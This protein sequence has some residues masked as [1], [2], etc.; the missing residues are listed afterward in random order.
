M[1]VDRKEIDHLHEHITLHIENKD[2]QSEFAKELRTFAQKSNLKG[3]RKGKTPLG[4]IRKM[5]GKSILVDIIQKKIDQGINDFIKENELSILGQPLPIEDQEAISFDPK[6]LKDFK[7]SFEIGISP[8]VQ[9]PEFDADQKFTKYKIKVD[10]EIVDKEFKL[11]RQKQGFREDV[12]TKIQEDDIIEIE[13]QEWEEDSIKE[14]GW[15]TYFSTQVTDL[16][17]EIREQLLDKDINHHFTFNIWTIEKERDEE[18]VRKHL[19]NLD[20]DEEKEIGDLFQGKIAKIKRL[21]LAELNEE[22]FQMAFQNDEV[23]DEASAKKFIADAISNGYQKQTE[24][25]LFLN[26]QEYLMET[27]PLQFPQ[28]FLKKWLNQENKVSDKDLSKEFPPF[29]KGLSWNLIRNQLINNYEIQITSEEIKEEF[30]KQIASYFGGMP[31][32]QA[33]I[34]N[35]VERMMQNREQVE[36]VYEDLLFDRIYDHLEAKI[37]FSETEITLDEF[38]TIFEAARQKTQTPI[39]EEEE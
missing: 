12:E 13:A 5:Y 33:M 8:D 34:D 37:S 2:Y 9:I 18:Y 15:N 28:A 36:K 29:I 22:F 21:R 20:E 1:K 35:M 6:E 11:L 3:F 16:N 19:L 27:T 23:N 26:I 38:N 32:N 14:K 17:D 4:F 31:G 10:D 25:L 39:L 7:F 30:A 24:A